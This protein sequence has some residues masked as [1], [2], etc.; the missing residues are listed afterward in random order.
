MTQQSYAYP[1]D[2]TGALSSNLISNE[3]HTISPP[4]YSDHYFVV[5]LVAPFFGDSLK[6]VHYGS[7]RELVEGVDYALAY[8]F[9]EA[10]QALAQPVYGALSIYQR[11]LAGVLELTYQTVGGVWA[12]NEQTA[13]ELLANALTNPRITTWEQVVETPYKFPVIDHEWD[14]VDLVGASDLVAA[15]D[16]ITQAIYDDPEGTGEGG[17]I[18]GHVLDFENPHQV[19]KAQIGLPFVP[20]WRPA[21]ITDVQEATAGNRFVPPNLIP[22]AIDALI[23]GDLNAHIDDT[24]NPH[25]VNKVQ[26]GL[27]QVQNYPVAD[28][29]TAQ[30]GMSNEHYLTVAMGRAQIEAMFGD[31]VLTHASRQDNPHGVTKE[32]V[33]LGLVQNFPM[34]TRPEIDEGISTSA[35]ISPA[36]LQYAF[37][38]KAVT[39]ATLADYATI[40]DLSQVVDDMTATF[41][42]LAAEIDAASGGS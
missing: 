26:V 34:A 38:T 12:I 2:P 7:G 37:D 4:D 11:D 6:V 15:I 21:T 32:Q 40:V 10:T 42:Q 13:I 9:N 28:L 36:D 17:A 24:D 14:L 1:F 25:Q 23:R 41:N 22:H 3:Q 20:D 5:P 39:H 8:Q 30:E 33:G 27:G 18:S 16:R 29:T 31:D 35:Y 19:T